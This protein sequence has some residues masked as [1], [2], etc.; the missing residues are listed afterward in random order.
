MTTIATVTGQNVTCPQDFFCL[1]LTQEVFLP[2]MKG[3]N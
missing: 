3:N 2:N 1:E